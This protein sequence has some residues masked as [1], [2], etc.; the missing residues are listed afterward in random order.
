HHQ[1]IDWIRRLERR[2]AGQ[3]FVKDGPEGIDVGGG[4]QIFAAGRLL[5]RHVGGRGGDRT[6]L[7][8]GVLR[9]VRGGGGV[10]GEAEVRNKWGQGTGVRSQ[11]AVPGDT[12]A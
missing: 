4:G 12:D 3:A 5:R 6:S 9:G 10:L 11:S 8:P 1:C 2:S 7:R